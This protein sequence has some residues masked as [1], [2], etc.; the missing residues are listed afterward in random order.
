M[1]HKHYL[2][3][4]KRANNQYPIENNYY[5][6]KVFIYFDLVKLKVAEH[7]DKLLAKAVLPLKEASFEKR[8]INFRVTKK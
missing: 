7:S 4:I 8:A 6:T 5:K 3:N 1:Y 2:F